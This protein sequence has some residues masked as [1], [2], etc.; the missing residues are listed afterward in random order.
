MATSHFIKKLPTSSRSATGTKIGALV[1]GIMVTYEIGHNIGILPTIPA[2]TISMED[3]ESSIL[4]VKPPGI[5]SELSG[6]NASRILS[7]TASKE[8]AQP[9][10]NPSDIETLSIS[11]S[12]LQNNPFPLSEGSFGSEGGVVPMHNL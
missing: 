7:G 11:T 10:E 3:I 9:E 6:I 4:N 5:E 2:I 8:N 12:T 1:T